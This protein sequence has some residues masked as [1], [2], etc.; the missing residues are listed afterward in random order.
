MSNLIDFPSLCD[1]ERLGKKGASIADLVER[2]LHD[3]K[4]AWDELLIRFTGLMVSTIRNTS[5]SYN[6]DRPEIV[7]AVWEGLV[8]HILAKRAFLRR[9]RSPN[10]LPA[11]LT[12]MSANF[13][14]S[15]SSETKHAKKRH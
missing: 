14:I 12:K 3:E 6:A 4:A 9:L 10:A 11:V 1:R 8:E 7:R 13:T 2:L 15:F 5:K